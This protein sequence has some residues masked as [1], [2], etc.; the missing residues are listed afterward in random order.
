MF[1]SHLY[2]GRI[3]G[4]LASCICIGVFSA[5]FDQYRRGTSL[6][7]FEHRWHKFRHNSSIFTTT[8]KLTGWAIGDAKRT[9]RYL[10]WVKKTAY[11]GECKILT[12]CKNPQLYTVAA[13]PH[14][15]PNVNHSKIHD[16]RRIHAKKK[17]VLDDV[18]KNWYFQ[19]FL[20]AITEFVSSLSHFCLDFFYIG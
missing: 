16:P 13:P 8:V 1:D 9:K 11:L 18:E 19:F 2:H 17:P 14:K 7:G 6:D 20:F 5:L 4:A 15:S 10:S 12:E 3:R